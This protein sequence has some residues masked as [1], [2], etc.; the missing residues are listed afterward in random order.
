MTLPGQGDGNAEAT[1]VDQ[2]AAAT[3]AVDAADGS[4]FVVGHSASSALAWLVADARPDQVAGV[5]MIGGI[6]GQHGSAYADFFPI[7]DGTMPFPGWEPF[8]GPDS[9]DLDEATKEHLA[10]TAIPVPDGVAQARVELA[11]PRRYD[12]PVVLFCPEFSVE[13]AEQWIGAGDVPEL[14]KA[15]DLR[16]VD[17]DSGHW[18]MLSAPAELARLLARAADDLAR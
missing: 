15:T 7:E 1:L 10:M 4:P 9:A 14:A 3:E 6:P 2:I 12:V 17:I 16:Y 13:Q 11:D 8:A 18:P 5:G